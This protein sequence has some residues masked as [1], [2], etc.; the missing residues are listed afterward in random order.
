M[1]IRDI[2]IPMQDSLACWPGDAPFRFTWTSRKRDGATVNVGQFQLSVHTGTH[3]DAP[4][5]FDDAGAT[6]DAVDLH[7]FIGPA[8]VI[9][10][11]DR[12]RLRREDLTPFDLS[13]TPRVLLR[14]DGWTDHIQFSTTIP[15]LDEDDPAWLHQ[16]GVVL[17]GVDVPSVDDLD[18]KTLP[19]HH[20]LGAH[21]ITILES[22]D[23][24]D[25]PGGLYELLAL[26]MRLVAADGAPVRAI[27]RDWV[28]RGISLHDA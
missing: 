28:G 6:S 1:T 2:T 10:L 11:T 12:V 3:T 16:Q 19:N 17:V 4:F 5:Q 15:V 8:Q 24:A 13:G 20:A 21:G 25:V 9:V 18:S 14:T 22:L 26:P 7:P 27:L 23:L